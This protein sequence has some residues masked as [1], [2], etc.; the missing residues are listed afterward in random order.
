MLFPANLRPDWKPTSSRSRWTH[1]GH[2]MHKFCIPSKS[3]NFHGNASFKLTSSGSL[4][5]QLRSKLAKSQQ[6]HTVGTSPKSR[7]SKL[8]ANVQKR[9]ATSDGGIRIKMENLYNVPIIQRLMKYFA[10]LIL[11]AQPSAILLSDLQ[12][13]YELKSSHFNTLP[14]FRGEPDEDSLQFMKEYYDAVTTIRLGELTEDQLRMR[15]FPYCMKDEAKK[16][17]LALPA[18]SLTT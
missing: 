15:C 12:R 16:W 11:G 10:L 5:A 17:L 4:A 14:V 9:P 7:R 3:T 6:F 2:P 8:A 18:G 13:S 1:F